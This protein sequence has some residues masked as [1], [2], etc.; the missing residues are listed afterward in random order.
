MVPFMVDRLWRTVL[1]VDIV[2]NSSLGHLSGPGALPGFRQSCRMLA[3]VLLAL[4]QLVIIGSG[5]HP[6]ARTQPSAETHLS[7]HHNGGG[8]G[9]EGGT[10]VVVS[11]DRTHSFLNPHSLHVTVDL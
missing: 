5:R 9:G 11:D 1:M 2:F 6:C 10:S 7:Q 4:P 3:Q 8:D